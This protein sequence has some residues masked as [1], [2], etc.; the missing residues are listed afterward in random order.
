MV[1]D[2]TFRVTDQDH[3]DIAKA[4]RAKGISRSRLARMILLEQGL[5]TT[6]LGKDTKTKRQ[7]QVID[8]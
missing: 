3:A 1:R 5:L 8:G 6:P 4:A 2:F 7:T